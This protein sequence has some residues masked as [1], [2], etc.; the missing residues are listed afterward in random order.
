MPVMMHFTRI[1]ISFDPYEVGLDLP[2][3]AAEAEAWK[4]SERPC[5]LLKVTWPVGSKSGLPIQDG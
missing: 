2:F 3:T 5:H 4:G 1:S